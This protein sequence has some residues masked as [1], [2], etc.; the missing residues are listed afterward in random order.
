MSGPGEATAAKR[1]DLRAS[2]LIGLCCLIIYNANLRAISAGDTYPARY[3]PFAVWKHH[4]LV[5]DPI[6]AITAQG[7]GANAYWIHTL[8]DGRKASLYPVT[9]PLL[10]SPLYL[11]A[12][13]YVQARGWTL[14]ALDRAARVMEKASA[15]LIASLS[16]S[17]LF[18]LLRRRAQRS[19]ALMLTIAYAFGT[20][21]WVISSQALWQHGMAQLLV[22]CALLFLTGRPTAPNAITAGLML[23]LIAANRPPDSLIAAA[24]GAYGLF[25]AGRRAPL[26]IAATLLPLALLLFYNLNLFGN[27]AGGYGVAGRMSLLGND[28]LPGFAGLLFSPTR[29]LFVFSPFLLFLG[30]I[31]RHW[32]RDRGERIL[33]LAVCV[34]I[35]LQLVL[36]GKMDWRGGLSWGPRFLTD[37]LPLLLWMLVPVA[38]ALRGAAKVGFL[39]AIAASITIEAIGAWCYT[40]VTDAAIFAVPSGPDKMR[41]A[42]QWRNA[43]FVTSLRNGPSPPELT[44]HFRGVLDELQS[45]GRSVTIVN[46]GE[47]AT[48]AGWALAGDATPLQVGLMIDGVQG[49]ASR[50]FFDRPDVR[51]SLG[52]E[53]PAGWL[54]PFDTAQLEPGDHRIAAFAWN[55]MKGDMYY[56]GERMLRIR[57]PER[58]E[59]NAAGGRRKDFDRA[60]ET[61]AAR[62]RDHQQAA[63]YWLT[64]FTSSTRFEQPAVEMNTFLTSFMIDLLDPMEDPARMGETLRRARQHLTAQI[65][66]GGLV[67]YHGLPDGPGIGTLGCAI[68]PDTDDT[69]LV[70]RIAPGRDRRQLA[71]ALKTISEYRT[72]E[73]LYRTWLASPENYQCLDPGKDPNPPDIA[74]QMNLLLLLANEQPAAARALCESI[75][76]VVDEDRVWVY[77]RVS[78]LIAMTRLPDMERAGC[79]IEL[80][81]S[82]MRTRVQE[83]EIWVSALRLLNDAQKPRTAVDTVEI[84]TLLERISADDFAMLHANPPLI[85]HNDLTASVSR[86]YWSEDFGYALWLRLAHIHDQIQ[87][88]DKNH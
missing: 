28:V 26:L 47:Q 45:D 23:G 62:V 72:E 44:I 10:I 65:G 19:V 12:V 17:L 46:A 22:V 29:G 70:W 37:L 39:I 84:G 34:A 76:A 58:Q 64:S 74:I 25:W 18:L 50:T 51:T 49:P 82:R 31:W 33:T 7:R 77:Y 60:F 86:Y 41:A 53:S 38:A 67:R 66:P 8:A 30:L 59:R 63:G 85:Y 1:R 36:Y 20:T 48:A 69:A 83:Q 2:I 79:A 80:P 5:L 54:I 32:P 87:E 52:V 6:E 13:S 56:L 61:A 75:R 42:W 68:T 15:S 88:T 40:S 16:A 11:P 14:S 24:L 27:V 21:T 57:E 55:S 43:P 73:G 3:L 4:T 78:P 81:E 71:A 9:T 35:A